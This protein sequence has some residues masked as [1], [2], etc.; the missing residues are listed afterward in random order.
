MEFQELLTKISEKAAGI[1][2]IGASIKLD[3][4]EQKVLI[5]GKGDS[6]VVSDCDD[7]ADCVVSTSM[8]NFLAL[9]KGDLNPMMAVMMGKIKIKGD[10]GVAMKLQSLIA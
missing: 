5:D 6:N 1:P 10:M 8:E 2:A 3:L 9:V 4:G 7:E